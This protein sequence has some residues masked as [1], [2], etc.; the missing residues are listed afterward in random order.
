[1]HFRFFG[2]FHYGLNRTLMCYILVQG[3][4]KVTWSISGEYFLIIPLRNFIKK[5]IRCF[6]MSLER[7]YMLNKTST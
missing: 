5:Q 4:E 1:M 6:R 3:T 2:E 7:C